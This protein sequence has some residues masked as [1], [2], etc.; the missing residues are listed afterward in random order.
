MPFFVYVLKNPEGKIYIGQTQDLQ[1]R[2]KEH[3]DPDCRSTLHT[4]RHPGPWRLFH[5]EEHGTR[6][7]A[8]A[9]ERELKSGLGREWIRKQLLPGC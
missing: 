4:K 8:M 9:R 5:N 1:K 6:R 3:N 2:L 7:E